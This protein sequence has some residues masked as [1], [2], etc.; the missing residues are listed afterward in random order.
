MSISSTLE[1]AAFELSETVLVTLR[2]ARHVVVLTGSELSEESGVPAFQDGA[3]GLA[4][5]YYAD[6]MTAHE[7]ARSNR[8]RL[9]GWYEWRRAAMMRAEPNAAHHAIASIEAFYP[10]FSV[11]TQSVDDLQERAGSREVLHLNGRLAHARCHRCDAAYEHPA[12]APK[13]R[14]ANCEIAP[15]ACSLCDGPVRPDVTWLGEEPPAE[16]WVQALRRV[17]QCDLLL[18]VGISTPRYPAAELVHI[19]AARGTR[20]LQIAPATTVLDRLADFNIHGVASDVLP[21]LLDALQPG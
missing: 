6:E 13:A 19:A 7:A 21:A 1:H 12:D 2:Q 9:W 5:R 3:T 20:V 17:N 16:D 10:E 14:H 18:T 4:A 15:P 8:N 11:I